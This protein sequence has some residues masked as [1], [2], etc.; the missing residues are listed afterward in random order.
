MKKDDIE[1]ILGILGSPGAID[2]LLQVRELEWTTASQLA[3]AMGI[4]VA[5]AVKR[6]NG[7]YEIGLLD[8]RKK[9]GRT[10]S[11]WEYAL[12]ASSFG[13]DID[14]DQLAGNEGLKD[15]GILLDLLRDMAGRFAKFSG[16]SREDIVAQWSS[17]LED[18]ENVLKGDFSGKHGHDDVMDIAREIV[19]L[20]Q[21]HY[22]ALTVRSVVS[23]SLEAINA[24][25]EQRKN[26]MASLF[27]G[28]N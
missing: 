27:G 16:K 23:A 3:D 9:S 21:E 4:H 6:L 12:E 13:L 8:R 19:L 24:G 17:R 28:S 11:A 2:T 25:P 26:I 7:L 1:R 14:L 18:P 10:R 20:E 22:G 5:T 15:S